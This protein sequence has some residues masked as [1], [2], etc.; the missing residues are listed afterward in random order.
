MRKQTNAKRDL[1]YGDICIMNLISYNDISLWNKQSIEKNNYYDVLFYNSETDCCD[2]HGEKELIHYD[3][4]S[5]KNRYPDEGG[6]TSIS[7]KPLNSSENLEQEVAVSER[8][9]FHYLIP[10]AK[11]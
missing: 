1:S 11:R 8:K 2:V 4:K 10:L 3:E 5:E 7:H 6:K 9:D